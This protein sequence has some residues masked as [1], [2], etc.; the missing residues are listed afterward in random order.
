M[1]KYKWGRYTNAQM[2]S[3]L[4]ISDPALPVFQGLTHGSIMKPSIIRNLFQCI[5]RLHVGGGN[6]P[7]SLGFIPYSPFLENFG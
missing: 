6:L 4:E 3:S 1:F 5:A 2:G 7:V